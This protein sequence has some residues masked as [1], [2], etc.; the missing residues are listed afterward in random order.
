MDHD[1]ASLTSLSKENLV[2]FYMIYIRP[3]SLNRAK[4]AVHMIAQSSVATSA[5]AVSPE[6]SYVAEGQN[7][8]ALGIQQQLEGKNGNGPGKLA[9]TIQNVQEF[10]ASLTASAGAKPV[11]DLSEF[12]E[13]SEI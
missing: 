7:V 2:E 8:P 3:S 4:T 12:K 11:R 5:V 1:V 6:W 9:R 10:K 13:N